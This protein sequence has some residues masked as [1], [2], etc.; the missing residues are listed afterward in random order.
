M[1]IESLNSNWSIHPTV[2]SKKAIVVVSFGT[3]Q[4]EARE[5]CIGSLE[6]TFQAV[7]LDWEI[8]RAF[9]SKMIIRKI[10][11]ETGEKIDYIDEALDRLA[12]EGYETV[13][14]QPTHFIKGLEYE[15]VVEVS[16]KYADRFKNIV[17]SRPLLE[18]ENSYD[19]MVDIIKTK[20]VTYIRQTVGEDCLV[21]LMGHGTSHFSNACYSQ[22]YLKMFLNGIMDVYVVTVEGFPGF[23]DL[24]KLMHPANGRKVALIPFMIVAGVHAAEDMASDEPD[25][26]KSILT[27]AG[28]EPVP[29]M[30]GMGAFEPMRNLFIDICAQCIYENGLD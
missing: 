13:V 25:S 1:G 22:L 12:E 4:K 6:R 27:E 16:Q 5:S 28:Y 7:F 9:T 2:K 20:V 10:Q 21:V 26:L 11:K 17:V 14:L 30:V 23:R 15:D 8:R 29:V 24:P 18:G 19:V 3:S